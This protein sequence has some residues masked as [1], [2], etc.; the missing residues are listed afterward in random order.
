[1]YI[2]SRN[3]YHFIKMTVWNHKLWSFI[4]IIRVRTYLKTKKTWVDVLRTQWHVNFGP[5]INTCTPQTL[6]LQCA[7]M[8][9]Q[10]SKYLLVSIGWLQL[11]DTEFLWIRLRVKFD[12]TVLFWLHFKV[13][14]IRFEWSS[15]SDYIIFNIF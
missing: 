12:I 13:F 6:P 8:S 3:Y 7:S 9:R 10:I 11:I 4:V 1:M 2:I 15:W 14:N 5:I